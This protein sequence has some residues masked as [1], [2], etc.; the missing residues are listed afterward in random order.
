MRS[1][2]QAGWPEFMDDPFNN[3]R[4]K[5][6]MADVGVTSD[7]LHRPVEVVSMERVDERGRRAMG[8]VKNGPARR[9]K[10]FDL[11]CDTIDQLCMRSVEPFKS[12]IAEQA[13]LGIDT[14]GTLATNG[15]ALALDRMAAYDWCQ[16]FAVWVP[17]IYDVEGARRFYRRARDWFSGQVTCH[18]DMVEQVRDARRVGNV[19]AS[20]KTAAMLTMENGSLIGD[21]LGIVDELAADGVKMVTL[22]WNGRNSIGSGKCSHEGLSEFGRQVVRAL[23]DARIV[24]DVSHL[25]DEGFADLLEVAR[26]PFAA[27]HSNAR[28][29][30]NVPR[31]LT[32]DEFRAIRDR[33]GV[34]GL[35]YYRGFIVEREC[36]A[37]GE[38]TFD[39]LCAHVEHFLDLGG[40]D[41][42][43][44][45][46]DYDGSDVPTW[47][48]RCEKVE[49]FHT[50]MVARFGQAVVD[51]LFFENAQAFFERNETA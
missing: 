13:K 21:D 4:G 11:H 42:L 49:G 43:A 47:L 2:M 29:V 16:C 33:G 19:L 10:V 1:G 41:T 22:T 7:R 23:E 38:A 12:K 37:G 46:S 9:T 48:D 51:K 28:S 20:G 31:N 17:D 45:G 27:S 15:G 50:R 8:E 18:S 26:R 36:P 40:E 6:T 14:S 3:Q 35:N 39:E 44:L 25:N 32:D 34:A 24:V 30:C 5:I